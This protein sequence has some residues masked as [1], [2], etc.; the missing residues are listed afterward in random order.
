MALKLKPIV[1]PNARIEPLRVGDQV[2]RLT[3]QERFIFDIWAQESTNEW[4]TD[5]QLFSLDTFGSNHDPLYMEP[6]LRKWSKPYKIRA[7][8]SKPT[9]NP[10]VS[11]DGFRIHFDATAWVSRKEL[12]DAGAPA[13][14]EGDVLQFWHLPQFNVDA[15]ARTPGIPN[16]GYYF[17]VLNATPSAHLFDTPTFVGYELKIKRRSE[18]GPERKIVPP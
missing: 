4:G 11:E 7:W 6:T 15:A 13:P 14:R 18:F 3:D 8:V 12:E 10:I 2:F 1:I 5:A 16:S 9:Q 17:D